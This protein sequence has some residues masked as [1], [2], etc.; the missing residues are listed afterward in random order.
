MYSPLQMAADLPENYERFPDAFQFI[1]DVAV[2]W[3]ETKILVAEPGDY[4]IMARKERD[5][6]NWFIGAI[7]DEDGR[8]FNLNLDFLDDKNYSA[9]IYSDGNDAHWKD[10]PMSYQIKS[11]EV[12]KN[13]KIKLHLVPSGG[14]AISIKALE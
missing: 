3:E 5:G 7:T 13:S 6:K 8:E 12:N 11:M 4:I 2:D 9:T 10:N 14:A 1:K